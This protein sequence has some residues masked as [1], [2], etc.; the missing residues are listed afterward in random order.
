MKKIFKAFVWLLGIVV[1]LAG[2]VYL[3]AW[4]SPDY[5]KAA[6]CANNNIVPFIKYDSISDHPRPMILE[7][8]SFVVFGASHTRDP[9]DPQIAEIEFKWKQLKPT[10]ALVEGR[11]DFLLPVL[12]TL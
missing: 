1:L 11:L 9:K 2:V 8:K 7:N 10:I 12:W 4:R 5:Y 3:V 6:A